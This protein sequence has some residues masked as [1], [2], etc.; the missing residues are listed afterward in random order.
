MNN[1]DRT[2]N[3]GDV[4][5]ITDTYEKCVFTAHC[6]QR[7]ESL[8]MDGTVQV[9]FK[10]VVNQNTDDDITYVVGEDRSENIYQ[11]GNVVGNINN[12]LEK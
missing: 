5:L 3:L 7:T 9:T 8:K 6:S 11:F 12:K 10:F 1:V 2:F 4:V